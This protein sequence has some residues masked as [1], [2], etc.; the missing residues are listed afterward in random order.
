VLAGC[1][2]V[3]ECEQVSYQTAGDHVLFIGQV[4]RVSEAPVTPL[5]FQSGH[6]RMLGEVL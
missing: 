5:V 2:A 1:A 4:H 3:F 6:Y